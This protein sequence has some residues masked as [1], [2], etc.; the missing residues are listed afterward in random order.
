MITLSLSRHKASKLLIVLLFVLTMMMILNA[1]LF[2]AYNSY[3]LFLVFGTVLIDILINP[4]IEVNDFL[5]L[6]VMLVYSLLVTVWNGG[7][8]GSIINLLCAILFVRM[9]CKIEFDNKVI[10]FLVKCCI[11]CELFVFL[12]SFQY[13]GNWIYYRFNDINPNTYGMVSAFCMMFII[14]GNDYIGEQRKNWFIGVIA[15]II[16][17]FTMINLKS[18][19]SLIAVLSFVLLLLISRKIRKKKIYF[20]L[21]ILVSIIGILFPFVYIGLFSRGIQLDFLGKSLYTGREFL[22]TRM[23]QILNS[24]KGGW[25]IGLGS[26]VQIDTNQVT[27]NVHN[28]YF[29]SIVTYGIVGLLFFLSYLLSKLKPLLNDEYSDAILPWSIMFISIVLLLGYTETVTHWATL[30]IFMFFSLGMVNSI[31]KREVMR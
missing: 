18:R 28:D 19:G 14:C 25:L 1:K 6:S 8:L 4:R 12:R 2:N 5:L 13:A 22:W 15:S 24:H 30:Y 7:G 16:A 10:K 31:A 27:N 23:I 29:V 21:A 26:N 17:V 11:A 9:I 20:I 3:A